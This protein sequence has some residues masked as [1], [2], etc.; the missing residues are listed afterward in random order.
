M[1]LGSGYGMSRSLYKNYAKPL[2]YRYSIG[3][4]ILSAIPEHMAL[5]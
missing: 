5:L 1:D 4:T 3:S 2:I